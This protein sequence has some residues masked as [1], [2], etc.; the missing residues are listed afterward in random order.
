MVGS[1][2]LRVDELEGQRW[3]LALE[4]LTQGET[5]IFRGVSLTLLPGALRALAQITW[6]TRPTAALVREDIARAEEIVRD[7]LDGSPDLKALVGNRSVEY[8]AIDD[9]GMG[10]VWLADLV[11]GK[12]T[13]HGEAG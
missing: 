13:W 11:D 1:R 4:R 6:K 12:F 2:A 3:E 10:A 8:H 5:V 7:A 9:Y